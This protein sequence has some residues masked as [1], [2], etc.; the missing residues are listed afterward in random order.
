MI[1]TIHIFFFW[2]G[3]GI[4]NIFCHKLLK[5]IDKIILKDDSIQFKYFINSFPEN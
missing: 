5:I 3:G 2:G 1:T 4:F